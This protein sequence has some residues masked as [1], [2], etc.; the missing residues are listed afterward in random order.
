MD[1]WLLVVDI[2][3]LLTHKIY[4]YFFLS[5]NIYEFFKIQKKHIDTRYKTS[6]SKST[7]DFKINLPESLSFEGNTCFYI[8]DFTCGHAWTSIEDF[9]NK[10]YL[11]LS[12]PAFIDNNWS[13]IITISN[14]NYTGADFANELQK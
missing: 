9:N 12:Q 4:R 8:D 14:G 7:S 6:D 3:F 1:L 10:F 11:H 2:S 13:F 5:Y